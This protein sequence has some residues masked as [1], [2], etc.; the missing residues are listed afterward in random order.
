MLLAWRA[1]DGEAVVAVFAAG[2][3]SFARRV[4]AATGCCVGVGVGS[5]VG[6]RC[7]GA[8]SVVRRCTLLS[9]AANVGVAVAEGEGEGVAV[10]ATV[11]GSGRFVTRVRWFETGVGVCATVGFASASL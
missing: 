11:A 9:L 7:W 8:V 5:V 2:D 1:S 10:L 4:T 6:C 3:E